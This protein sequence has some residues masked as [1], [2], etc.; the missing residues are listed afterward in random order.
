[1]KRDSVFWENIRNTPL[2]S[3]EIDSY[4]TKDS[5]Q[6]HFDSVKKHPKKSNFKPIDLLM[7]GTL[8]GDSTLFTFTHGGI[9]GILREYNFVDGFGW[10]YKSFFLLL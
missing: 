5:L 9:P 2:S 6:K 4:Q 8:G 7:G 1:M 10:G 3:R